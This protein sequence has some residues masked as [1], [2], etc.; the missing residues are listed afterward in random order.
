[1]EK[2]TVPWEINT[3]F[4]ISKCV[5]CA[6]VETHFGLLVHIHHHTVSCD[7]EIGLWIPSM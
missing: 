3:L 6:S 2:Q 7:Q 4:F 1:M 5:L